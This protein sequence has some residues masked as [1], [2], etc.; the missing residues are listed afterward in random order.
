MSLDDRIISNKIKVSESS[1]GCVIEFMEACLDGNSVEFEHALESALNRGGNL[2]Q[3]HMHQ[4]EMIS[5]LALSRLLSFQS[6]CAKHEIKV[7]YLGIQPS[8]AKILTSLKLAD[9]FGLK[10]T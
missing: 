5:S 9:Y 3:I 8:L 6:K 4:T 1:Q 2:V 10:E 7:S